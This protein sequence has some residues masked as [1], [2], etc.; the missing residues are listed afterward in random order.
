VQDRY[1]GDVGDF[2]KLGLL[3]AVAKTG[4]RV[5]VNW[6]RTLRANECA[7]N[8]DGKH[9]AYL[10]DN[11]YGICDPALWQTLQQIVATQRSVLALEEAN[12]I[13]NATYFHAL[14]DLKSTPQSA[15]ADWHR[16]AMLTLADTDIV[17][18][19][20]DNGL[21]VP[22]VKMS[23]HKSDKYVTVEELHDYYASGKSVVFYNHRSRQKEPVYLQRFQAL[24]NGGQ[25]PH[26]KWMGLKFSRGTT[27]DYLF[28][29]QPTHAEALRRA[30]A[31]LLHSPWSRHFSMVSL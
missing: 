29:V 12:L 28:I 24:M 22:S 2:G 15:R 5:G 13:P 7:I 1:A 31:E 8:Q 18:C 6:Y 30:V 16:E 27:R 9:I 11:A 21:L 19:D 17:F 10:T 25:F 23:S 26:A 20:P 4:L 14:L 3:R